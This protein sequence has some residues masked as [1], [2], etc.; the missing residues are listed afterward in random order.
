MDE[1]YSFFNLHSTYILF[2]FWIL[3]MCRM[4]SYLETSDGLDFI[5]LQLIEDVLPL[6]VSDLFI[7]CLVGNSEAEITGS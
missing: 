5:L 3:S 6:I 1:L 2:R 4:N 7:H